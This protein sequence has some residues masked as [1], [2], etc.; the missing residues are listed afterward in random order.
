MGNCLNLYASPQ[1]AYT[2]SNSL[3][4]NS[5]TTDLLKDTGHHTW[6]NFW[7]NQERYS[8]VNEKYMYMYVR[9]DKYEPLELPFPMGI[10]E[11]LVTEEF[12]MIL[13]HLGCKTFDD[14]DK[15]VKRRSGFFKETTEPVNLVVRAVD[16][17]VY[18][19]QY[20]ISEYSIN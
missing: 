20:L 11:I 3:R 18:L 17:S 4:V 1:K 2:M 12:K 15:L 10:L 7:L 8:A 14:F 16:G 19:R 5:F 9:N 13:E 6:L